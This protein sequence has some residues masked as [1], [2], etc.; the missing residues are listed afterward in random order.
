M[1]PMP[2]E[3]EHKPCPCRP[4]VLHSPQH[5][6]AAHLVK[7][8]TGVNERCPAWL[9]ILSEELKGSQCPLSP[10]TPF[11]SLALNL[12]VV[13]NIHSERYLK[14]LFHLLFRSCR[15]YVKIFNPYGRTL[16]II[17]L[18]ESSCLLLSSSLPR[19]LQS[20]LS[21]GVCCTLYEATDT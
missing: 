3:T 17:L 2:I 13:L 15:L 12:T 16:C 8:I 19:P 7:P 5:F 20:P 10:G 1:R 4:A 9:C 14:A 21:Y 11:L 18:L 6:Q